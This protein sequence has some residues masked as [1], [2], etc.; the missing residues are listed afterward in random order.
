[1]NSLGRRL[2]LASGILLIVF[3]GVTGLALDSAFRNS[4]LTAVQDRLQAMVYTLLAAAETDDRG[5]LQMPPD[6]PEARFSTPQSGL[7]A[8]ILNRQTTVWK[9]ASTLDLQLPTITIDKAGVGKFSQQKL[10]QELTLFTLVFDVLWEDA[11]QREQ[12]YSIQVFEDRSGFERQVQGFR[13]NLWG[14]FVVIAV[15]LELALLMVLRWGLSPLRRV[16]DDLEQIKQGQQQ[17]LTASY[18]DELRPFA[19]SINSLIHSE[20][21]QRDRYR[22]SLGDIA[23]SLKTPLAVVRGLAEQRDMPDPVRAQLQEQAARMTQIVDYQLQRAAARG[24]VILAQSVPLKATLLRLRDTLDKVYADRGLNCEIDVDEAL[25]FPGDQGDLMELVGNLLD[26][27]YKYTQSRIR[28][29]ASLRSDHDADRSELSILIDDDGPGL[30]S[31]Q[32]EQLLHR[33][34]R[35]DEQVEGQGIGLAVVRD[36]LQSYDGRLI[37]GSSPM[38]GARVE[39]VIPLNA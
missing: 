32:A 11:A 19:D 7:Y 17:Q 6:L 13:K 24:K 15:L 4:A 28:I 12:R 20:R 35:F 10:E 3:L 25:R 14:W 16:V 18:P 37:L 39:I 31:Q 30:G 38:Q 34:V 5:M 27:A 21:S 2:L 33:G 26:N 36:I 9:S 8:H 23:H 22:N 29:S 1:M